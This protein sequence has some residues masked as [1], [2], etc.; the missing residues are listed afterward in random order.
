MVRTPHAHLGPLSLSPP[1]AACSWLGAAPATLRAILGSLCICGVQM[2][3]LGPTQSPTSA[4]SSLDGHS[5]PRAAT[6]PAL[7]S[8]QARKGP[9]GSEQ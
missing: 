3:T 4:R 2:G 5:P 8:R 6:G 7:G 1:P 9:Q